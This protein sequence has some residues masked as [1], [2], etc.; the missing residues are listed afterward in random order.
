[1]ITPAGLIS[2]F[3]HRLRKLASRGRRLVGQSHVVGRY[4]CGCFPSSTGGS[5]A[6]HSVPGR[7]PDGIEHFYAPAPA[8]PTAMI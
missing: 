7:R 2:R 6:K 4:K 8:T 3:A 1:M 5:F